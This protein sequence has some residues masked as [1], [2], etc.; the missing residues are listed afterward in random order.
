MI[1]CIRIDIL[2]SVTGLEVQVGRSQG[3]NKKYFGRIKHSHHDLNHAVHCQGAIDDA[4][5]L[6]ITDQLMS[7]SVSQIC[8]YAHRVRCSEAWLYCVLTVRMKGRDRTRRGQS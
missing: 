4:G 5:H 8:P 3:E 2:E 1:I 6:Y 7:R